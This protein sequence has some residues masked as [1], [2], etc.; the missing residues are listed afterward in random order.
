MKCDCCGKVYDKRYASHL[1]SM[2]TYGNDY[3]K[4]CMWKRTLDDRRTQMYNKIVDTCKDAGYTLISPKEDVNTYTSYIRYYC[5]KHGENK[6]RVGNLLSGKRCMKCCQ[7]ENSKKL[8]FNC[9]YVE[10]EVANCGGTLLNKEE[11]I[12]NSTKNLRIIC[13]RCGKEFVTSLILFTQHGGQLCSKCYRKESVGELRIRHYLEDNCI[14]FER[15]KW[16]PD[17]R[18]RHPLPFDF[19]LND[20]N[21]IIEFDGKQHFTDAGQF[22]HSS[23]VLDI[24][25]KHDEIKTKYCKENGINL[26]R[27]PYWDI[28]N[29]D[30][31]LNEQLLT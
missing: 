28:D 5:P 1:K 7:E 29:I 16:F 22:F 27:I 12:N 10:K 3:C 15:E 24:C 26:I 20:S 21:T 11:Y 8:R 13:P 25:Q 2:E 18:D 6:I 17:C 14:K 4:S 30:K 23:Y 19:Y 9:D 31:I